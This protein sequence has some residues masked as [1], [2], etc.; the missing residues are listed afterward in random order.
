[1]KDLKLIER[2]RKKEKEERLLGIMEIEG[3]D[4]KMKLKSLSRLEKKMLDLFSG[5]RNRLLWRFVFN[6]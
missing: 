1:M 4:M 3:D 2:E 6:Y 5:E